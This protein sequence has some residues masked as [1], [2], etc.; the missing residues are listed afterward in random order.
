MKDFVAQNLIESSNRNTN[1]S[2]G[3]LTKQQLRLH[4]LQINDIG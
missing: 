1:L 2:N 3:K 4:T